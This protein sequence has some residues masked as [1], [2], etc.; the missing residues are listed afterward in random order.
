LGRICKYGAR[1]KGTGSELRTLG[2]DGANLA[3]FRRADSAV[4]G[5]VGE[6]P[7]TG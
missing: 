2:T 3:A 7:D 4:D 1:T 5:R 6:E